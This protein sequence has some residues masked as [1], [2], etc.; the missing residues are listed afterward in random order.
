MIATQFSAA[1]LL[2]DDAMGF[3]GS[4]VQTLKRRHYKGRDFEE[5]VDDGSYG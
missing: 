3:I 1:G 5:L 4:L 2:T